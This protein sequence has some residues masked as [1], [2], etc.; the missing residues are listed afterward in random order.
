MRIR[1]M[2]EGRIESAKTALNLDVVCW[3]FL[4]LLNTIFKD[5]LGFF[6]T[7]EAH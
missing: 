3:I 1:A 7:S 6:E 2:L 4:N 5:F